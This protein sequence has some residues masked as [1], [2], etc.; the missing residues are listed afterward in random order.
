MLYTTMLENEYM[1]MQ[2]PQYMP[3]VNEMSH[4][5]TVSNCTKTPG[6]PMMD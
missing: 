4:M 6:Y 1:D 3:N 2:D 5:Q